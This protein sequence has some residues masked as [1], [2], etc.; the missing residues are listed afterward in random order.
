MLCDLLLGRAFFFPSQD[1]FQLP[2]VFQ[3]AMRR[4]FFS[5]ARNEAATQRWIIAAS[6]QRQTRLVRRRARLRTF[7][8]V[9]R[10]QA[11]V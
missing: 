3:P 9:R 8:Q 1:R 6:R 4:E 7:D 11:A 5:V 2:Q 10:R